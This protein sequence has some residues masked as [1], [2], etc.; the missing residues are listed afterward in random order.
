MD[1][2]TSNIGT[3]TDQTATGQS[4][5][6]QKNQTGINQPANRGTADEAA[7]LTGTTTQGNQS[8]GYSKTNAN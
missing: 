2:K 6:Q 5:S 7:S 4:L 3:G 8:G 1:P